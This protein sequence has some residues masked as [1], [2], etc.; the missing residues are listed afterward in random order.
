MPFEIGILM[1]GIV[2][3]IAG[4]GLAR[5]TDWLAWRFDPDDTLDD[6]LDEVRRG[7]K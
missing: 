1:G 2:G 6:F 7:L 4:F 5:L 3:I